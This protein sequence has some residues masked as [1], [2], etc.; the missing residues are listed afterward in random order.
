VFNMIEESTGKTLISA[1]YDD[2]RQEYCIR[3]PPPALDE[4][5]DDV[6]CSS[7]WFN[8]WKQ[9][10]GCV[11]PPFVVGAL[12]RNVLCTDWHMWDGGLNPSAEGFGFLPIPRRSCCGYVSY[13]INIFGT[14]PRSLTCKFRAL[15]FP[16]L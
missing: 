9:Q 1:R 11:T 13:G 15:N 2:E 12:S 14:H 6:H 16:A 4:S 5:A 3:G 10:L 7:V 8:D